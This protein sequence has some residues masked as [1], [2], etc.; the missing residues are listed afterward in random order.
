MVL[1]FADVKTEISVI[2]KAYPKYLKV[3]VPAAG[4]VAKFE[5]VE[6]FYHKE[7]TTRAQF[8]VLHTESGKQLRLTPL[9]LIPFGD[10]ADIER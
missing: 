9:H 7:P 1:Q 2:T 4:N 8:V 6:M 3:L 10:C 5:R